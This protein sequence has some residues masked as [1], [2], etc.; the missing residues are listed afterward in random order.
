MMI[1]L[2][3]YVTLKTKQILNIAIKTFLMCVSEQCNK[4]KASLKFY[5][6]IPAVIYVLAHF[7]KYIKKYCFSP[8]IYLFFY[9]NNLKNLKCVKFF[10]YFYQI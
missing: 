1:I 9:G 5:L 4:Y 7:L 6:K 8:F 2:W 10:M 3:F